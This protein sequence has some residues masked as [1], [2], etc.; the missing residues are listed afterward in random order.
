MLAVRLREGLVDWLDDCVSDDVSVVLG[1]EVS[2]L[3]DDWLGEEVT[4]RL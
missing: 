3:E 2:L 4:E 1:V